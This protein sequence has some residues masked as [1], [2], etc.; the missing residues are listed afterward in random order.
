MIHISIGK[1]K[2]T[3]QNKKLAFSKK[4]T[5][6]L[7][8]TCTAVTFATLYLCYLCIQLNYT[9]SLPFLSALIGLQEIALG[10]I[11]GEYLKKSKA[12]NTAGGIVHDTAL[13]YSS[14]SNGEFSDM[15]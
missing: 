11:C 3:K 1:N 6:L 8:L 4:L 5:L 14:N 7:V 15:I 9:G 12:E 13:N 10:Y 2:D